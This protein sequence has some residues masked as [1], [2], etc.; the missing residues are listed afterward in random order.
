MS[1]VNKRLTVAIGFY[2]I[3]S[4]LWRSMATVNCLVA[5]ILQNIFFCAQQMNSCRFGTTWGREWQ[6]F[7][8]WWTVPL[9][10]RGWHTYCKIS[11]EISWNEQ[12]VPHFKS[13][14]NH[15]QTSTSDY[16]QI[17]L[18]HDFEFIDSV[19]IIWTPPCIIYTR[20]LNRTAHL[21]IMDLL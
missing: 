18:G 17:R 12:H 13:K 19:N 2:Y 9:R 6:N 21:S 16:I 8:F 3:F 11:L 7:H 4:I 14:S 15:L 1:L 20:G 5:S 10:I